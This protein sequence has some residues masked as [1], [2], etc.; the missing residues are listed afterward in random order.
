MEITDVRFREINSNGKLKAIVS[1]TFDEELVVHDIKIIEHEDR[2]FLAMPSV[3]IANGTFRDIAHP[4][5]AA[6]RK[7]LQDEVLDRYAV[8]LNETKEARENE[9]ACQVDEVCEIEQTEE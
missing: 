3:R 2:M 5:T 4:I 1:V 7:K 9:E 6:M 8:H